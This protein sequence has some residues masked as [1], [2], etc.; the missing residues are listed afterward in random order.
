M[1]HRE[2]LL[3]L[4]PRLESASHKGLAVEE[5]RAI[6]HD[7]QGMLQAGPLQPFASRLLRLLEEV[8]VLDGPTA[9]GLAAE[10]RAELAPARERTVVAGSL[11]SGD[12]DGSSPR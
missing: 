3:R 6:R 5:V 10:V 1:T 8:A 12:D 4:Q 2:F 9:A 11:S 7:L